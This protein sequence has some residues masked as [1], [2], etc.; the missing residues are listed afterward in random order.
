[1][2]SYA[3]GLLICPTCDER[4]VAVSAEDNAVRWVFRYGGSIRRQEL[5]GDAPILFGGRD[6]WDSSRVDLDSRWT[7]SLPRIAGNNVIVTPRDSDE[8]F[9]LDLQTGQ[10]RWKLGRN[11]F[12]SIA[13]IV[14][15]KIILCGNH[16]VQ[17][18]RLDDGQ[19]LW[20]QSIVDGI[21]CGLP[22]TDGV[23]L[24]IPTSEP[25]IVALD[26]QT[27]RRLATQ[28]LLNS[29]NANAEF[30]GMESPGNLLIIGDQVLSQNLDSIRAYSQGSGDLQ[31]VD[32]ALECLL[33]QDS[34]GRDA[35]LEQGLNEV[36]ERTASRDLLIEVLLE[37]LHTEF[38]INQ[39]SIGRIRELISQ[40]DEERPVAEVLH[41]MLGMS[42]T[43]AA[44]L[45]SQL[46]R[47][48]QAPTVGP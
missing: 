32:Q 14:D 20:S 11:Q 3:H 31:L 9:C 16:I 46:H 17:A 25:A 22:A 48:S 2:P 12:H 27:G 21:V 10:E 36:S 30:Q 35:L 4:I 28:R 19:P 33:E 41:L 37:S 7:D 8:L 26:V 29:K 24:Q 42:L 39:A 40:A 44:L 5:G 6:P 45:P 34:V 47:R 1:M 38:A 18:F 13:A 15:D 43:D 23:L